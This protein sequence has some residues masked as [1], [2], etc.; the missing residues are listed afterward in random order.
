MGESLEQMFCVFDVKSED[1]QY[2]LDVIDKVKET[3]QL[4]LEMKT[5]ENNEKVIDNFRRRG[6]CKILP[7]VSLIFT[8][9][10]CHI[11]QNDDL[12]FNYQTLMNMMSYFTDHEQQKYV[13]EPQ[14]T[15]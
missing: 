13:T 9:L 10:P 5:F 7:K 14:Y 1:Q 2:Q 3:F 11:C 12:Y 8:F 15:P 6:L 4:K